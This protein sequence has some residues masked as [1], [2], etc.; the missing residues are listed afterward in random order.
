M[1]SDLVTDIRASKKPLGMKTNAGSK[2]LTLEGDVKGFGKTWFDPNQMANI[3]GFSHMADKYHITYN[4]KI[5]DTFNVH[6][7]NGIVKF[8]E[9]LK[10]CMPMN[11]LKIICEGWLTR[12]R[13]YHQL[14]VLNPRTR[15]TAW[16]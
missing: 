2:Q 12:R 13:C 11:R 5:E 8:N 7:E 16:C 3:F 14:L 6:T 4:N 15:S 9:H 10:D 1:N